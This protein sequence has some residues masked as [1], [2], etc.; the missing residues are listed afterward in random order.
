MDSGLRRALA[1]AEA[2]KALDLDEA[3]VLLGARGAHLDRVLAVASQVRDVG[4]ADAGRPGV[5]TYSRKVF[6]PLTRLFRDR[7]HY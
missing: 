2:G 5:V 1:R 3:T 4:V 7:C 6:I